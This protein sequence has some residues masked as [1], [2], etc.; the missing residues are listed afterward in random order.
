MTKVFVCR[1]ESDKAVVFKGIISYLRSVP[2][3][4]IYLIGETG[5][6]WELVHKFDMDGLIIPTGGVKTIVEGE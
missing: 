3:T 6:D 4:K 5:F 2:E 1:E